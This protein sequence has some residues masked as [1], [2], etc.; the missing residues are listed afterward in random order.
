V[1]G[2]DEDVVEVDMEAKEL[3]VQLNHLSWD[4][5]PELPPLFGRR[6]KARKKRR[7][8]LSEPSESKTGRH[9]VEWDEENHLT[10]VDF[11]GS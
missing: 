9:C 1:E 3:G 8:C 10:A 4:R 2:G 5:G 7:R 11:L 6:R